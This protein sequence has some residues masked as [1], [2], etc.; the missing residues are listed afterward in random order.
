VPDQANSSLNVQFEP[1]EGK[2]LAL[3]HKKNTQIGYF[4]YDQVAKGMQKIV[5]DGRTSAAARVT[6]VHASFHK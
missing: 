1:D 4:F 2:S 6:L 5:R 3:R